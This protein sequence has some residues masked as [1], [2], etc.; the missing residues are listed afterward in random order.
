MQSA[1][2]QVV[3]NT[4]EMPQPQRCRR[5]LFLTDPRAHRARIKTEKGNVVPG[6]CD[7]VLNTTEFQS[8]QYSS[9]HPVDVLWIS[10][11]PGMG[12]TMLSIYLSELL[13]T[14][15]SSPSPRP[16]VICFFCDNRDPKR[17]DAVQLLRG[18]L[19]QLDEQFPHLINHILPK[20][21]TQGK[22][23]FNES[24]EN[25]WE[26][27]MTMVSDPKTPRVYCLLDGLDEC[28]E[29]SLVSLLR[30]IEDL[31]PSEGFK[32][33][34]VRRETPKCLKRLLGYKSHIKLDSES[35]EVAEG[36]KLYIDTRIFVLNDLR[37]KPPSEAEDCLN[38]LPHAL[39]DIYERTLCQVK[40]RHRKIVRNLLEWVLFAERPLCVE[41]LAGALG[42]DAPPLTS[43]QVTRDYVGFCG[44]FLHISD[45][46][47]QF[48]HQ[49]AKEYLL[50][51]SR[52]PPLT[53]WLPIFDMEGTH[54]TL[55]IRCIEHLGRL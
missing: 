6:I 43:Y 50:K 17:N 44:D 52:S 30:K 39:D 13:E 32:L 42:V 27:L 10:G 1:L 2:Q 3:G 38:H 28:D 29:P 34:V 35:E 4:D 41:E 54:C 21:M 49:T 25:L 22:S 40:P 33:L 12:K 15:V 23:L 37:D 18:L 45:N 36:L 55:A 53:S 9:H 20:Y 26:I 7:W 5:D 51:S 19:S 46:S 14:D 31:P 8:W 48:V 16:A 47:V 24:I 11:G